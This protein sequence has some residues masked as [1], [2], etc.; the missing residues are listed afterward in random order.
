MALIT[1]GVTRCAHCER[2]IRDADDI[3]AFTVFVWNEVDPLYRFND[4]VFHKEC[5][6]ADPFGATAQSRE[7]QVRSQLGPGSHVCAVCSKQIQ[8]RSDNVAF[9]HMG[10]GELASLNFLQFHRV[11][12]RKWS[13]L[14]KAAKLVRDAMATGG[15]KGGAYDHLMLELEEALR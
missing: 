13:D 9:L 5:L 10:D 15:L 2:I 7:R 4:A 14:G 12:L 11:C 6:A 8:E 3:T 1:R